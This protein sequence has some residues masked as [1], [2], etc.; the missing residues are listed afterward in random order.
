[1]RAV[2]SAARAPSTESPRTEIHLPE[3]SFGSIL[4]DVARL[5][6]PSKTA[7][8]LAAAAGCGE[9]AAEM[10]LASDRDWSG[11]AVAA[12]MAEILKR[13]SV[14]NLRIGRRS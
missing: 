14:R 13:H 7:A 3:Q 6:W 9:R 10:Y 8:H 4:G 12:I 1:M 11:D 2:S 5:L